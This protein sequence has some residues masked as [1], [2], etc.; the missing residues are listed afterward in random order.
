MEHIKFIASYEI[1]IS[2]L[3]WKDPQT[4]DFSNDNLWDLEHGAG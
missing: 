2:G 1:G 4:N 3:G